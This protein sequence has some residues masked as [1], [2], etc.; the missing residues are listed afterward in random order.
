M[1]RNLDKVELTCDEAINGLEAKDEALA[2]PH[3]Y[4]WLMIC[5]AQMPT[6]HGYEACT[7][8]RAWEKS[9]RSSEFEKSLPQYKKG[10]VQ[11]TVPG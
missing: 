10:D 8:I 3:G 7:E 2:R 6:K 1:S 5:N 11:V 9:M 4:Y